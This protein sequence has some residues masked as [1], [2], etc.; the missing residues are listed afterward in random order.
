MKDHFTVEKTQITNK[1]LVTNNSINKNIHC[2]SLVS[3]GKCHLKPPQGI[4]T[5]QVTHVN[6]MKRKGGT[7]SHV[8]FNTVRWYNHRTKQLNIIHKSEKSHCQ[9]Y[10]YKHM[11][12]CTSG[13]ALRMS[14]EALFAIAKSRK[15]SIC[16][17]TLE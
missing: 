13:D 14:T 2:T 16:P 4:I 15:P 17:L 5:R 3:L 6:K 8:T 12:T 1:N 7:P 9:A 11:C 10:L